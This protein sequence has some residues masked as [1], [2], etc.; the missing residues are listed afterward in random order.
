MLHV[1]ASSENEML[2]QEKWLI[3]CIN[4]NKHLFPTLNHL[5]TPDLNAVMLIVKTKQA[6]WDLI[7]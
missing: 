3:N 5:I 2:A 1:S 7:S 4:R 6:K